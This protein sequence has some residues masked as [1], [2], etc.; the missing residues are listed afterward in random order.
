[1]SV[2]GEDVS[3]KKYRRK[4]RQGRRPFVVALINADADGYMFYNN[5]IIKG[6]KGGEDAA[7][8]LLARLVG[9][10]NKVDILVKAFANV[11]GLGAAL[12][13]GGKAFATSFSSHQAF[14]DF[15]NVRAGKE[16]VDFKVRNTIL[17]TLY[18]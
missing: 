10:P 14:F 15:I 13:R 1:M 4:E 9:Q 12:K 8:A 6:A 2:K 16:W 11:S 7:D 18:S 17:V 3:S 5:F